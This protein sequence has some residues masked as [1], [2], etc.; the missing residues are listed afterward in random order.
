LPGG[1]RYGVGVRHALREKGL[2]VVEAETVVRCG[3]KIS[4]RQYRVRYDEER[5]G[6]ISAPE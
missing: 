3:K 2:A 6:I 4:C 1:V 5:S